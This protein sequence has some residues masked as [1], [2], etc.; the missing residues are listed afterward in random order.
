[1]PTQAPSAPAANT[2]AKPRPS[3][4][5]PEASTGSWGYRFRRWTRRGREFIP[6]VC[7]PASLP[8]ATSTSAPADTASSAPCRLCT[9]HITS[10]LESL[11]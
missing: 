9:W 2:A 10:A 6:P 8:W 5:P 4:M 1:M 3:E 11:A 7:P